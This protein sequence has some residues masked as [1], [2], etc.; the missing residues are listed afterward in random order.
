MNAEVRIESSRSC[1][2]Y[3]ADGVIRILHS[4]VTLEG[5]QESLGEGLAQATREI[6]QELGVE[7]EGLQTLMHDGLVDP[8]FSYRVNVA[9][10]SL[11]R[12]SEADQD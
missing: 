11:V 2:L 7:I 5:A 12:Y 6:A 3:D 4:E 9:E 1:I 8:Q 10:G